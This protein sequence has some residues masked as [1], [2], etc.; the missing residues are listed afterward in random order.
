MSALDE[1]FVTRPPDGVVFSELPVPVKLSLWHVNNGG[2]NLRRWVASHDGVFIRV[3]NAQEPVGFGGK[4]E[5]HVSITIAS[6]DDFEV[7]PM[8]LATDMEC[9]WVLYFLGLDADMVKAEH[10]DGC[11]HFWYA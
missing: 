6:S 3:M 2:R 1:T 10:S 11:C 9:G 7:P 5:G 4:L 8:R